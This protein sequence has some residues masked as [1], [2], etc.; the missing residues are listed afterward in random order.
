[1]NIFDRGDGIKDVFLSPE[2]TARLIQ[3]M[4][5]NP[6][7]ITLP[8]NHLE[9]A[10]CQMCEQLRAELK[11]ARAEIARLRYEMTEPAELEVD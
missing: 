6:P 3:R 11:E 2:E 7:Q 9:P 4:Q 5:D 8:A 1:M 10:P